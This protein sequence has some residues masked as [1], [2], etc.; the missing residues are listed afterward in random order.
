MLAA[1]P[2]HPTREVP[3]TAAH[4]WIAAALVLAVAVPV[5]LRSEPSG[6]DRS[7][8]T[9]S[10]Y[11]GGADSSQ[12]SSLDQINKSTVSR[13][14]V[15]WRYPSADTRSYRFNPLVVDGTMYVLAR[16]NSIVALDPLTGKEKWAHPNEGAVGDRGI[17]YWESRDRSDRRLLYLN[18][19]WLTAID[20]RTGAAI[21]SFGNQGRVDVRIGPGR[22][23]TKMR[24]LQ[25]NNPGRI[26]QDLFI[27][28]LPAGGAGYVANP[29][30][31]HAYDVRT[32]KQAWVFHT[33]P[34]RGESH[35]V[36]IPTPAG[37]STPR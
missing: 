17:N 34:V 3:M 33:V 20:A 14:D 7:F 6:V 22:D 4:R 11:L 2:A 36:S 35:C 29:G 9:W 30:D 13:L 28:S 5:L 15:V 1:N 32:G 23:R 37:T 21:P 31:I 18:G 12:Y 16:N 8:K 19:G 27:I 25:T 24:P 10:Q 26:Y